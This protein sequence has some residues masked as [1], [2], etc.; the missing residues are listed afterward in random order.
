M[1]LGEVF[2]WMEPE[3]VEKDYRSLLYSRG[4][5][6]LEE[7]DCVIPQHIIQDEVRRGFE[8]RGAY[9]KRLSHFTRGLVLGS[10]EAVAGWIA[11]ISEEGRCPKRSRPSAQPNGI[12]FQLRSQ[13]ARA[14]P[15]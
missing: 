11:E 13:R 1:P 5:I 10:R 4:A 9:L 12:S 15:K 2:P 8:S 14:S 3:T 7:G 6:A